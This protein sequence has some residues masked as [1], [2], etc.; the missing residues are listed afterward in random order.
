MPQRPSLKL[1]FGSQAKS[2]PS[3]TPTSTTTPK[4]KLKFGGASKAPVPPS[5]TPSEP[6]KP[7]PKP[8]RKSKPT[9]KKRAYD[10]GSDSEADEPLIA[11]SQ[12]PIKK[13]KLNTGSRPSISAAG[14]PRLK[15]KAKGKPL[16][17]PKG[18][19]Y[20]SEAEDKEKD[21]TIT[22][23]IILRMT[24][25]E[26][27]DYLR[28]A[29]A[30]R[31]FGPVKSGGADVRMRFLTKDG[32]RAMITIRG[33][34]YAAVLVDLPC[35]IEA[36][37]S[38]EKKQ[39][40]KSGDVCQ[41]LLVLGR[42]AGEDE[43]IKYQLPTARG[44]LDG[45]TMQY[46]HGLTPP[47]R[48][49]R[50]RRFRKRISVRAVEQEEEEVEEMLRKDEECLPGTSK[51]KHYD[52]IEDYDREQSLMQQTPFAN[53]DSDEDAEGE[54]D[55]QFDTEPPA[56]AP[57][58]EEADDD[59][60]FAA[61]MERAMAA[62][63]PEPPPPSITALPAPA[64]TP[65][66][67]IAITTSSAATDDDDEEDEESDE[68]AADELDDEQLEQQQ[69]AQRQKEEI[70]DLEAAI[71]REKEGLAKT[72]NQILRTKILRKVQALEGDLEVKRGG[73]G[74]G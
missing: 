37:K 16:Y 72:T 7:S 11:A 64:S 9:P 44:E 74:G 57:I 58:E 10:A 39:W 45:K 50:R 21:P 29:V 23:N 40:W 33:R 51:I 43:A 26:D 15:V 56:S 70:A 4:I 65:Q 48:W 32:R 6:L 25:G 17:R 20:D 62:E 13:L 54:E 61:E 67:D 14:G 60:A 27:C 41:M 59:D 52:S 24:P 36:M 55:D 34:H 18:V 46:A 31:N 35:V 71:K 49:V 69:E 22:D 5:S 68:D 73:S 42:C 38:W 66:E 8:I 2:E 47:M 53:S 63:D 1:K 3:E 28:K 19:G 12:P 30:D